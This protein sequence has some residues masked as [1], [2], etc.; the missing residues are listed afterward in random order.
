M[1]PDDSA[2]VVVLPPGHEA[3]VEAL[4]DEVRG[5]SD[6]PYRLVQRL[7][8]YVV[9][10][11]S[12]LLP[13]YQGDGLVSPVVDGLWQWLGTYDAVRGLIPRGQDPETLVV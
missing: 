11:Y 2:S 7:Q 1:I 13:Q 8:P 6:A 9:N 4:L 5:Q 10:I 3:R 12:H